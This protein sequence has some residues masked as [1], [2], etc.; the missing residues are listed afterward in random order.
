MKFFFFAAVLITFFSCGVQHRVAKT[1]GVQRDTGFIYELPYPK[2]K[3]YF[4][5]QGYNSWLSHRDRLGLDFKMK[6]GSAVTAARAG[7]VSSV[8][9]SFSKGGLSKK[10][11]RKAN[12]VVVRHTDGSFAMYGH[13][14]YNGAA[15]KPGD[16]VRTGQLIGYSG[17]VGYSAF[18][19][20]HF[21][22]WGPTRQGRRQQPTRFHTHAGI[23]YLRPSRWYRSPS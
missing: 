11:L 4:L 19:H 16:N 15:V 1:S 14:G 10:Y 12:S 9:E 13:L 5:I 18:P 8:Q 7:V 3:S 20:L 6:R 22:V 23:G 2:G 17:S 21:I